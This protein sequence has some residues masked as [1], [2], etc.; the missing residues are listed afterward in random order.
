[1]SSTKC[2]SP[3]RTDASATKEKGHEFLVPTSPGSRYVCSEAGGAPCPVAGRVQ[4]PS[5]ADGGIRVAL[6]SVCAH[7]WHIATRVNRCGQQ[8]F[9][10]KETDRRWEFG[11]DLALL[12]ASKAMVYRPGMAVP[13]V[14][15][16]KKVAAAGRRALMRQ[17]GLSQHTLEAVC[18]GRRV[19]PS[20]LHRL[21]I[22]L[23]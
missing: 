7:A 4:L 16:Q 6:L 12:R 22:V 17:N 21:L 5:K 11:E 10:G 9:V 2:K 18:S 3:P 23:N 20:T 1:M 15:L 19:R 8:Y 13:P 14:A